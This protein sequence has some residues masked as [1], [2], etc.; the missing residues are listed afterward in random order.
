MRL[1]I[2]NGPSCFQSSFLHGWVIERLDELSQTRIL[3]MRRGKQLPSD[4]T[5]RFLDQ[6]TPA[7]IIQF[8]VGQGHGWIVTFK[9]EIYDIIH[10][11]RKFSL[12]HEVNA[13][14]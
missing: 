8:T 5:V 4:R 1:R 3:A 12:L 11:Q 14:K 10:G 9:G 7:H 6:T 2:L 13:E